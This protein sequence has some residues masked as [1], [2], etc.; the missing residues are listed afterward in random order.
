[1]PQRN[2]RFQAPLPTDEIVARVGAA[3][4]DGDRLFEPEMSDAGD[5]LMEDPSVAS[6]RIEHGDRVDRNHLDFDSGCHS[7][8]LS[9]VRPLDL[10]KPVQRVE[11]VGIE[12]DRI[13]LREAEPRRLDVDMRQKV[14]IHWLF[15]VRRQAHGDGDIRP[16]SR[17]EPQVPAHR[18][19]AAGAQATGDDDGAGEFAVDRDQAFRAVARDRAAQLFD[20]GEDFAIHVGMH[21]TQCTV[22][23]DRS[24][25]ALLHIADKLVDA[26]EAAEPLTVGQADRQILGLIDDDRRQTPVFSVKI[27]EQRQHLIVG[28]MPVAHRQPCPRSPEEFRVDDCRKGADRTDPH[29][30][31]VGDALVGQLGGSPVEN[32]VADIFLIGQH[33]LNRPRRPPPPQIRPDLLLVENG[34][35]LRLVFALVH[36][37][38]E[39][40]A[41]GLDFLDRAGLQHHPI[42]LQA[43]LLAE[44]EDGLRVAVLID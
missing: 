30:R 41:D 13:A 17:I 39:H 38:P 1:L 21:A 37:H 9:C 20:L 25:G 2:K 32:V 44:G 8:N 34:G 24:V 5:Q 18:A 12:K 26:S 4:A 16:Q 33:L 7:T 10:T 6:P 42:A 14:I 11:A 40:P 23:L 22:D 31:R 36:E 15:I 19:A 28:Q 3:T 27:F 43:L 29:F 35:D